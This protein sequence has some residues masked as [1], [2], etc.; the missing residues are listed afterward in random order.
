M[1]AAGAYIRL[2]RE[3]S[4]YRLQRDLAEKT[5]L[6]EKTISRWE[7]GENEPTV[8]LLNKVLQAIG[9]DIHEAVDLILSTSDINEEHGKNVAEKRLK[10]VAE[11]AS[12]TERERVAAHLRAMADEVEAGRSNL[13]RT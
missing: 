10:A 12:M 11:H 3:R 13:P 2:L 1:I 9:G 4:G 8:S 6:S 7:N 5:D